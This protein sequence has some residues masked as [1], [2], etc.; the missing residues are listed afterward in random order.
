MEKTTEAM[1]IRNC[2][3]YAAIQLD[4][5]SRKILMMKQV[6][7]RILRGTIPQFSKMSPDEIIKEHINVESIK[8]CEPVSQYEDVSIVGEDPHVNEEG[9]PENIFDVKFTVR[10]TEGEEAKCFLRIDLEGQLDFKPGYSL[11][12]RANYHMARQLSLSAA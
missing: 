4:K 3:D 8:E 9:L 1:I 6:I 12:K 5:K 11:A 10:L 2:G 7:A